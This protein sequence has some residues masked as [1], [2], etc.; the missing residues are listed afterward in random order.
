MPEMCTQDAPRPYHLT[1]RGDFRVVEWNYN[2]GRLDYALQEDPSSVH[3]CPGDTVHLRYDIGG[4]IG[5]ELRVSGA[6]AWNQISS[7]SSGGGK[8]KGPEA[9][10][11]WGRCCRDLLLYPIPLRETPQGSLC[12]SQDDVQIL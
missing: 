11:C 4:G 6:S 2:Q 10:S 7:S 8:G 9:G 1:I 12:R 3:G 5:L